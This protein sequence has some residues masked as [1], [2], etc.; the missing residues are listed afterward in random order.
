VFGFCLK[1][2]FRAASVLTERLYFF[3]YNWFRHSF[4]H[5]VSISIGFYRR[6]SGKRMPIRPF[7]ALDAF[8]LA[9]PV[10]NFA[11]QRPGLFGAWDNCGFAAASGYPRHTPFVGGY[12]L[13]RRV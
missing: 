3:A 1:N 10:G 13:L 2:I 7:S 5:V 9:F 11:V 4:S 6:W 8:C 12:R